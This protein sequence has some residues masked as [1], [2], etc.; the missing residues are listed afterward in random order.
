M[1]VVFKT[2]NKQGITILLLVFFL[3]SS[4]SSDFNANLDSDPIPIVYG[5]I[6]P[7]DS[8]QYIRVTRSFAGQSNA[9]LS[10]K[11]EDSIYIK[12]A[13]VELAFIFHQNGEEFFRKKMEL[14]A[15]EYPKN[16]GL[17]ITEPNLVFA[18]PTKQLPIDMNQGASVMYKVNLSIEF[19]DFNSYCGSE[20]LVYRRIRA[21][22]PKEK[23][24]KIRLD[25]YGN[26]RARITWISEKKLVQQ[27]LVRFNYQNH[28]RDSVT[29][30]HALLEYNRPSIGASE[31]ETVIF[32][33]YFYSDVFWNRLNSAIPKT[34]SIRYRSFVDIDFIILSA[35]AEYENFITT[36]DFN[37]DYI[38][39]NYSSN[40]INGRGLF[41]SKRRL[42]LTGHK[43]HP[44]TLDSLV[45]GQSTKNLNF[46]KW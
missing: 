39:N 11:Q 26:N 24:N 16:P 43:L 6:C 17:F 9:Y 29:N 19:P 12:N 7:D 13:N 1:F 30:H 37:V 25:L 27:L 41:F 36:S 32:T 2:K 44:K 8:I 42:D 3:S 46:I 23:G 21:V 5:S 33:N 34:D 45:N 4:C 15:L 18:I 28:Y 38:A 40:I 14:I 20:T 31:G 22:Y 10:A 35:G